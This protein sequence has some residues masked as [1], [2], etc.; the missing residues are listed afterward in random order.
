M[1]SGHDF[2]AI[3]RQA[4]EN[5]ADAARQAGVARIVYLGGLGESGS[6]LSP[7]LRSRQEVGT[8]L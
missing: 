7:H 8:I 2:E 5:F 6:D 1:G 3:D 4:A